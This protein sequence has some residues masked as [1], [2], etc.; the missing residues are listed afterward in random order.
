MEEGGWDCMTG[1]MLRVLSHC[2]NYVLWCCMSAW[3]E[4]RGCALEWFLGL[5]D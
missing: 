2:L 3:C 5:I 1:I 4:V